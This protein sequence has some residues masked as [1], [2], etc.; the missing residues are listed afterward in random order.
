MGGPMSVNDPLPY[1]S[2]EFFLIDQAHRL[3]LPVLESVSA[4]S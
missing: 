3:G 4:R 1:I 2:R